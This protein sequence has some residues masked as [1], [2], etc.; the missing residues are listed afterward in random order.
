MK[1]QKPWET[2][3]CFGRHA[4]GPQGHGEM[5]GMLRWPSGASHME[6]IYYE[7][8]QMSFLGCW[9]HSVLVGAAFSFCCSSCLSVLSDVPPPRTGTIFHLQ[10]FLS[11]QIFIFCVSVTQVGDAVGKLETRRLLPLWEIFIKTECLFCPWILCLAAAAHLCWESCS[12]KHKFCLPELTT[13]IL[14]TFH[15]E[16][17]AAAVGQSWTASTD[18]HSSVTLNLLVFACS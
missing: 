11:P 12:E 10:L 1:L 14:I 2:C 4:R 13:P 8:V 5:S 3:D 7:T 17:T 6:V 16:V 15:A 18:E 9:T